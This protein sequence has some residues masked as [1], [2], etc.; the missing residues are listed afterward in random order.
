MRDEDGGIQIV[1]FSNDFKNRAGQ[2]AAAF[3]LAEDAVYFLILLPI[4]LLTLRLT[5]VG[6]AAFWTI[7]LLPAGFWLLTLC[8]MKPRKLWG[9]ILLTILVWAAIT[10]VFFAAKNYAAA[11]AM[12]FGMIV[13]FV[14][15]AHDF[16][17]LY[18]E[19]AT[20]ESRL[21]GPV[22][23]KKEADFYDTK[24]DTSSVYLSKYTTVFAG[25]I[26]FIVYLFA[27]RYGYENLAVLCIVDFTVIFILMAVYDQ[28]SGAY[29]LN[30]WD[31]ASKTE[32]GG[33]K[34][35]KTGSSFLAFLTAVIAAAVSF[36]VYLIAQVCGKFQL[37]N[38]F[39]SNLERFFNM[40]PKMGRGPVTPPN[41]SDDGMKSILGQLNKQPQKHSP[42]TDILGKVLT[43]VLWCVVIA[44]ILFALAAIGASILRFYRKLNLNVNEESRS[45]LSA[46][47]ATDKIK[48]RLT[49]AKKA[50]G[51]FFRRSNRSVIRRLFYLHIRRHEKTVRKSDTPQ[52]IGGKVGGGSNMKKAAEIYEMARYSDNVCEDTDVTEMRQALNPNRHSG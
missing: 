29:C 46:E 14:K 7:P 22:Y 9:S 27:L 2:K 45:L 30:Q 50:R 37:D 4:V 12:F 16:S 19:A 17:R 10:A 49:R 25:I 39:I 20:H 28:K 6:A 48:S 40:E 42:F 38:S 34:A 52:E 24:Q 23:R 33:K 41:S 32:S 51:T 5:K 13:S 1:R 47:K 36:L 11:V 26:I 44:V 21:K 43:A 15:T 18:E 35:E 3:F 8:R 31:K